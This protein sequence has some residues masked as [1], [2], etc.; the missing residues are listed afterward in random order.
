MTTRMPTYNSVMKDLKEFMPKG[1]R[2]PIAIR[3]KRPKPFTG[4]G[5]GASRPIKY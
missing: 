4:K 1:L 3:P 2:R 5:S